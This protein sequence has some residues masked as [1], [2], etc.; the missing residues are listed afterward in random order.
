MIK[1]RNDHNRAREGGRAILNGQVSFCA[2][3]FVSDLGFRSSD[4]ERFIPG[5]KHLTLIVFSFAINL[6]AGQGILHTTDGKE[7]KGEIRLEKDAII[8]TDTNQTSTRVEISR[9]SSWVLQAGGNPVSSTGIIQR[10]SGTNSSKADLPV[11]ALEPPLPGASST[12]EP[13]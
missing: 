3:P 5:K 6:W 13:V 1:M 7:I 9:F 10:V 12:A 2:F 8:I 4:F 11:K